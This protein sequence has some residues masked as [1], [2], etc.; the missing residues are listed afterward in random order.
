MRQNQPRLPTLPEKVLLVNPPVYDTRFPWKQWQQPTRLL[1]MASYF[2][3]H[4]VDVK[5]IDLL[6]AQVGKQ[7][8]RKRLDMLNLDGLETSKW[9]YGMPATEFAAELGRLVTAGWRP[10]DVYVD[11]FTTFWWEGAA[12]VIERLHRTFES[13]HIFLTGTY[14][15]YCLGHIARNIKHA[16]PVPEPFDGVD[17]YACDLS[18]YAERPAF[19][20]LSF[21]NG[22]VSADDI[23]EQITAYTEQGVR[24]FVFEEHGLVRNHACLYFTTLDRIAAS[25]LKVKLFAL[26]NIAPSDFRAYPELAVLLKNARYEQIW[27]ADDRQSP[28]SP[29][30]NEQLV[31]DYRVAADLCHK[32]GFAARTGAVVASICIGRE[33]EDLAER[34]QLA[35]LAAHHIGSIIYW[36]YQ[37]D[38]EE[39]PGVAPEMQNG[40]I[41]PLRSRNNKTYKDYMEVLGLASVLNSKYRGKTFDFM[42]E[43]LISRLFRESMERRAWEP[44]EAVKG[45]IQLPLRVS[46]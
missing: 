12:E 46:R 17:R 41:F 34:A 18:L 13:S 33:G 22:T 4:N 43:N 26:G 39:C 32:A 7:I 28:V 5:L 23:V 8:T 36:A 15:E 19:A 30:L 11:C 16:E 29:R 25:G 27:L 9:R 14:P 38:I 42:S 24:Q 31:D 20:Y 35:T 45:G 6:S 3:Q 10:D 37:P 1:R 44:D 40:K 21:A 2:K